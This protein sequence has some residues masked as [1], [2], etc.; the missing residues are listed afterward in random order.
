MSTKLRIPM[1][2]AVLLAAL[3]ASAGAVELKKIAE[4]PIPGNPLE[5]FDIS[6]VDQ[7]THRLYVADRSNKSIDIVDGKTNKFV[8]RI[9]G[10]VGVALKDGKPDNGHSGPNGVMVIG[11]E[12]WAGDGDSTIKVASLKT[13]QII[14]TISTGGKGRANELTY[15]SKDHIFVIGNQVEEIP[16]VTMVSTR[17]GHKILGKVMQPMATDGNEQPMYNPADGLIYE[18]M[19]VLNHD[20]KKGG[21]MVIDPRQAKAL[22]V[23]EV[24]NCTP[25]GIAFGPNGNF[26]LGC[27]AANDIKMPAQTAI[28][29]TKTGKLVVNVPG[30]GGADEIN[31]NKK[32]NQYY[33]T[34]RMKEGNRLGVIDAATNKLVQ[35]IPVTGGN[36]HS[37][38]SDQSNGHVFLPVGTID[39][40]CGCIQV[41]GP[42]S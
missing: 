23:W 9:T 34:A 41:Y 4:V 27:S 30:V 14:D 39:G 12:V 10:F 28:M 42:A 18:P 29:N 15:D 7:K 31:Y 5:S 40:G 19:P 20:P 36:P 11:N 2:A 38:A 1:T 8:G 13:M 33:I 32:N 24:E 21:V 26:A 25:N 3:T 16:F 35:K 22:K 37:V 6:F 17:K